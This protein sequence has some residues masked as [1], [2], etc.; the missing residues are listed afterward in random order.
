MPLIRK[1]EKC[2]SLDSRASWSSADDAAKDGAFNNWTCPTCAW[3]ESTWSKPSRSPPPPDRA[4]G[5]ARR[6]VC[7][8][9][10]VLPRDGPRIATALEIPIPTQ[11]TTEAATSRKSPIENRVN[12]E[13]IAERVAGPGAEDRGDHDDRQPAARAAADEHVD[14]SVED[15][16]EDGQDDRRF[17]AHTPEPT[18]SADAARPVGLI[19][20]APVARSGRRRGRRRRRTARP[21]GRARRPRPGCPSRRSS[22]AAAGSGARSNGRRR[23]ASPDAGSGPRPGTRRRRGAAGD[24]AS[25]RSSSIVVVSRSSRRPS[26]IVFVSGSIRLT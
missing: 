22:D 12:P 14:R 25:T 6:I 4:P 9:R 1:C 26:V 21:P 7:S 20:P 23:S 15:A 11:A 18:S 13:A 19:E 24:E 3:T 17:D 8:V 5:V 10:R 2:G 16:D